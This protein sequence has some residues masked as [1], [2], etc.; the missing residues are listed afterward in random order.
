M[1]RYKLRLG[2]GTVLVVD[3]EG[4]STWLA[5]EE[6]MVQISAQR[7]RPLKQFV[8]QHRAAARQASRKKP[9]A[10]DALPLVYPKPREDESPRPSVGEPAGVQVLADEPAVGGPESGARPPTAVDDLPVI[11]LKPLDDLPTIPLKPLEDEVPPRAAFSAPSV[12]PEPRPIG[13]PPGVHV[14]ADE[15]AVS[16]PVSGRRPSAANDDLAIIPL[17]P[18]DDEAALRPAAPSWSQ[19]LEPLPVTARPSLPVRMSDPVAPRADD[20]KKRPT[21]D[22]QRPIIRLKPIVVRAAPGPGFDGETGIAE[23][24]VRYRFTER[25]LGVVS[26]F[27]TFLSRCLDPINRL[28]RGLSPFPPPEERAA[29]KPDPVTRS[30]PEIGALAEDPLRARDPQ[31]RPRS[32]E[33]PPVLRLKPLV[34]DDAL[35]R[36]A[37]KVRKILGGVSAWV[38]GLTERVG[39]V[40]R[41]DRPSPSVPSS[42]PAVSYPPGL[43]P[44]EPRK[45]PLPISELPVLRLAPIHEPEEPTDLYDEGDVYGRASLVSVL[46]FWTRRILVITGL[47]A[48]GIWAALHWETWVPKAG[49]LGRIVITEIDGLVRAR[50]QA[51]RQERALFAAIEQVPHLAR[52]TI[53]LVLSS[54]PTGILEPPEVFRR[55]CAA[56]GRGVSALS[57]EEA[58]ELTRLHG[59]L[60]ETLSPAEG[61]LARDYERARAQRATFSF[62]DQDALRLFARGARG[63]PP[64]S[65]ARLQALSGKAIAASLAA[66]GAP[67]SRVER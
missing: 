11:P 46:W 4:L 33:G 17:K 14:L 34:D 51:E 21:A 26:R 57:A 42:E 15:P 39:H 55:A 25:L 30:V 59:E 8:A 67:R 66:E 36:A 19:P 10:R 24:L 44:P 2:D 22:D 32:D 28:E 53:A 31:T 38:A 29:R 45:A 62:E 27:G 64:R 6:A 7:W 37:A 1:Q 50:H 16:G 47:V 54:S 52:G 65:L 41:R 18:L 3:Y 58:Q 43:A 48:G 20:K 56:E 13:E 61:E 5:D 49:R 40:T 60:L 9:V 63:L 23:A 35:P 12:P